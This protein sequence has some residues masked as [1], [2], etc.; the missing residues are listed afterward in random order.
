MVL[1]P[2]E[3]WPRRWRR[4]S[5]SSANR[6]A[7]TIGN[8][9][10]PAALASL[11]YFLFD[12]GQDGWG[13]LPD[14]APGADGAGGVQCVHR[15]SGQQAS[16]VLAFL[17]VCTACSLTALSPVRRVA[18]IYRA[19][20]ST[21]CCSS[22]FHP[23]DP[24]TSPAVPSIRSSAAVVAGPSRDFQPAGA[25]L[26]AGRRARGQ[27]VGGDQRHASVRVVTTASRVD[28]GVAF[29]CG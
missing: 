23:T 9:F 8:I 25:M 17:G 18:G 24:P 5:R 27:R 29:V 10:N 12:T 7:D 6:A 16:M 19:P 15:R 28:F 1:S 14:L 13:A 3:P 20:V 2:H 22:R 4:R 26:S 11:T 21:R